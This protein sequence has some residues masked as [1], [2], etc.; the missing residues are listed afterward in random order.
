LL[1]SRFLL[2]HEKRGEIG[3]ALEPRK[4]ELNPTAS[5]SNSRLT[6][7]NAIVRRLD[8]TQSGRRRD[9]MS[10]AFSAIMIVGAV[11]LP[12]IS[13]GMTEASTTR[14]PSSPRTFNVGSTTA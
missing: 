10:A 3:L 1:S 6:S 5:H 8:A 7:H 11:V 14:S 4:K 13:V 2:W 9:I 12:P